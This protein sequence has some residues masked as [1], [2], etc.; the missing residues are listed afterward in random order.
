MLRATCVGHGA[1]APSVG[2]YALRPG[3]RG[4]KAIGM[5]CATL[6]HVSCNLCR[7]RSSLAVWAAHYVQPGDGFDGADPSTPEGVADGPP[8]GHLFVDADGAAD[9]VVDGAADGSVLAP[10]GGV[11]G[12]DRSTPTGVADG[13]TDG[14][15][16]GDTDDAADSSVDGAADGSA[17]GAPDS[18]LDGTIVHS[19]V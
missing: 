17:A 14:K 8:D 12:T 3:R 6:W 11:N 15:L 1:V 19:K 4:S 7:S 10:N 13:P 18:G 2:S 9:G 5:L 16:L